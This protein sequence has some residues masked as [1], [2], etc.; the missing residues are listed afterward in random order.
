[1]HPTER[2]LRQIIREELT[3]LDSVLSEAIRDTHGYGVNALEDVQWSRRGKM[4]RIPVQDNPFVGFHR[5][6]ED[7]YNYGVQQ[8]RWSKEIDPTP[9]RPE[10]GKLR[11]VTDIY[12]NE[13]D[14]VI[15]PYID[16]MGSREWVD[17]ARPGKI[18][19]MYGKSALEEGVPGAKEVDYIPLVTVQWR[20]FDRAPYELT[21]VGMAFLVK[22]A[23]PAGN[24]ADE[25]AM[26]FMSKWR[27]ENKGGPIS[28][29]E[30]EMD[31][32][33]TVR[34]VGG[35]AAAPGPRP[36]LGPAPMS[37]DQIRADLGLKRRE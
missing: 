22:V 30:P 9:K 11:G 20:P 4:A 23:G 12:F 8:Q 3:H 15:I 17:Y 36:S 5:A 1:M 7:W 27:E 26:E 31:R 14:H 24:N 29:R 35:V 10:G 16:G 28:S 33:K 2:H 21:N 34:R 32:P 19:T 18:I 25:K 37:A 13:G 6:Y